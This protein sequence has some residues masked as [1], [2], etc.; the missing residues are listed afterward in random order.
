VDAAGRSGLER[1]RRQ[2]RLLLEM[3]SNLLEYARLEGGQH[4]VRRTRIDVPALLR[5]VQDLAEPL[6]GEKDVRLEVRVEP[7]AES[8]EADRERLRRIV[9]NLVVNAVKYTPAGRVELSAVR[10]N[11]AVRLAVHD[12]GPG[13]GPHERQRIFDPFYRGET[14][15]PGAG[16]GLGLALAQELA[17]LLS[18]EIVVESPEGEGAT[19]SLKLP[20]PIAGT[21]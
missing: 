9:A 10:E 21:G 12:T 4:P 1:L 20:A 3:T 6:I 18:T 16:V 7:G 2:E 5:E 15:T 8:V 19:F 14:V 13:I 11:G 17:H